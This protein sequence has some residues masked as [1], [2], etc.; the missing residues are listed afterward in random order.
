MVREAVLLMIKE[1]S[2][3]LLETL[4]LPKFTDIYEMAD[5]IG[6]N[7]SLIYIL[8]INTNCYYT[9]F[10]IP[11]KDGRV[12][13]IYKPSYSMK[14]VQRWILEKILYKFPLT[15]YSYAFRKN[16]SC[17]LKCNAQMH[18]E[19]M[20]IFKMDLK[21]FFPSISRAKVYY[22]F[23]QI[24]YNSIIANILT[25]ICTLRDHIPQ[26]AVTSPYLS[27]LVCRTLDKRIAGYC[28]RREIVYTRY[29]DDL[30]FSSND[31]MLLKSIYNTIKKIIEN[32]GYLLNTSKTRLQGP[33]N[34]KTITGV[35]V[36]NGFLK[37]SKIMKKKVRAMIHRA[38]L[39]GCYEDIDKIKGYIAYISSIEDDY[40]GKVKKYIYHFKESPHLTSENISAYNQ[41]KLFS[42]IEL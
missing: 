35:T 6:L 32:E 19:N 22:L 33:K 10:E 30:T 31:K 38:I 37:A 23:I 13:T 4:G 40:L 21:D 39:S 16:V 18:K 7:P 29:A 15:D 41:H 2:K 3:F 24:G 8:S 12:R 25:N 5:E 27:N 9:K 34:K 11:K 36:N 26:G 1:T 28:S 17:P 20:F 42:D 14:M